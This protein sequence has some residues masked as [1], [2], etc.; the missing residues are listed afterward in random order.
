MKYTERQKQRTLFET[1]RKKNKDR[2][3]KLTR[4]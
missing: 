3:G 1:M 4:T 2:K